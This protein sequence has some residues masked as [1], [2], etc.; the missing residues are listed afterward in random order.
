MF[1]LKAWVLCYGNS[2]PF[3][4]CIWKGKF[5]EQTATVDITVKRKKIQNTDHLVSLKSQQTHMQI[6]IN[7]NLSQLLTS[8]SIIIRR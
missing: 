6:E 4:M 8:K 3:L 1:L 7:S 2:L 5:K